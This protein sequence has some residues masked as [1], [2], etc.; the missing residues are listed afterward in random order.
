VRDRPA[1]GS[2]V[3]WDLH[4]SVSILIELAFQEAPKLTL[5]SAPSSLSDVEAASDRPRVRLTA[6][7]VHEALLGLYDRSW[8]A[9]VVHT[10]DLAPDFEFAAFG[11][12]GQWLEEL[13][14]ALAIEDAFGIE[15][16]NAIDGSAVTARVEVDD[17]LVGVLE[18][19]DDRVGRE[20]SE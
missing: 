16:G 17:L 14:L 4:Q 2:W 10:Q 9:L 15:L 20:G 12:Y 11:A 6:L 13:D 1:V 8:L 5:R 3:L 7:C 18:W 19:Q